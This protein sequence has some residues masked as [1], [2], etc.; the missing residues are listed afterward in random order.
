MALS[1][2]PTE[3]ASE[4]LAPYFPIVGIGASAGGLAAFEAFFAGIP[5]AEPGMAFVLVQHLAPDHESILAELVRRYTH[6]QVFEVVDGMTVRPNCTYIIPPN[7]DMEV[8]GGVLYLEVPAEARGHRLPV[9]TF[10][11][12]LAHDQ[13]ERAIGIILSGTG[14][15]GT[16]GVRA[17][18]GEGGMVMAQTSDT[19][20]YDGMPRNAM[21]TGLVDYELPPSEM[22]PQ[23]LAYVARLFGEGPRPQ[24]TGPARPEPGLNEVL[25]ALRARTGHDFSQY[26]PNTVRRRIERRMAVHSIDSLTDYVGFLRPTRD[27]V[28]SL[29]HDLMIGVTQFFRDPES[30]QALEDLVLPKIFESKPPGGVIRVWSAGC[31]TGEEAYSLAILLTERMERLKHNYTLQLFATDIDNESI[32]SARAGLFPDSIAADLSP[33]RLARF[34]VAETAGGVVTYRIQKSIRDV[35]IFSEQS[36]IKDPPFS[37]LD[38]IVCRNVLIY[39]GAELQRKL[40]PLFHYAL[41]PGGFLFLGTSETVGEYG[42]LFGVLDRK[43]KLF[44]RR[45][46]PT[47]LL[48]DRYRVP[49]VEVTSGRPLPLGAVAPR[50]HNFRELTERAILQELGVAAALVDAE[51]NL[52]YLHGRTGLYLELPA[53]ETSDQNILKMAREGLHRELT[54]SLHKAVASDETIHCPRL[55]VKTN[56]DYTAVSLT[57]RPVPAPNASLFLVLLEVLPPPLEGSTLEAHQTDPRSDEEVVDARLEALRQEVRAGQE[58][59]QTTKEELESS[60]EEL[61]SAVEEMQSVN[62]ELQS[63]NEELETSR[64]EMQSVNEELATVN[65]EL[66]SKVTD[67]SRASDDMNNLLAGTGVGTIFVD[68]RSRISRFTPA[69]AELVN[70][71]P[72]DVGRPVGHVVS[73]LDGYD[74]LVEDVQGVLD[75]LVPFEREVK[76]KLGA[77][78]M[79]RIRPYRTLN[80]VI[81][82]AVISFIDI[83][84]RK[85]AQLELNRARTLAETLSSTVPQPLL[86]LDKAQRIVLANEAF[87]TVF[88]LS[89]QETEGVPIAQLGGG[90][91]DRPELHT[92]LETILPQHTTIDGYEMPFRGHEG[93][94]SALRLNGRRV[95]G[96]DGEDEWVLLVMED[97]RSGRIER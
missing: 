49:K 69:A 86:L 85:F 70:L 8:V 53:G 82:G 79:L 9:D 83:G 77:W 71:I 15:D 20:E 18:K 34:F 28:D 45:N 64:E 37:R 11:R 76:T 13:R 65:A 1:D 78:F 97:L 89:K 4:P 54:T 26:K 39:M 17:I 61:R 3:V 30:F 92:L 90:Q 42:A 84:T 27:E 72:T 56:G 74:R 5:V 88:H 67:L 48:I 38:L 21:A 95:L 55:R 32:A 2:K 62:E 22:A 96:A 16:L 6:M 57:V 23:L 63:A 31:S 19:T 12:S 43:S 7:R 91:W 33:E 58:Y 80:N 87:L 73:N 60:N 68:L 25:S 66:Q 75:T 40:L 14:S 36:I 51:G 81:E 93:A 59:I 52:L 46:T 44:E 24:A 41:N 29:F 50:A 47:P 10:F 35:V 94:P